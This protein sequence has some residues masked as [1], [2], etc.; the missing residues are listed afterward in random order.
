MFISMPRARS[1]R[2][3]EAR[4]RGREEDQHCC[5][6]LSPEIDLAECGEVEALASH[7]QWPE[8]EPRLTVLTAEEEDQQERGSSD[9]S[10]NALYPEGS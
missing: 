3:R 1:D 4:E 6:D 5:H 9:A 8:G 10:G 2:E 7:C